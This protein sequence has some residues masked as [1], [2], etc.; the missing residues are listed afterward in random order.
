M[1][2]WAYYTCLRLVESFRF[3]DE[4]EYEYEIKLKVFA[5]VLK[6]KNDTTENFIL[7][8]FTKEVSTVL[9]LKEV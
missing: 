7:L 6:K 3:E 4:N 8:F 1:V 2:R 5:R 9:I